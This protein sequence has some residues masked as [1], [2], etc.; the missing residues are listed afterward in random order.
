M[1]AAILPLFALSSWLAL[2]ENRSATELAQS[3][4]RFA[5]SLVAANQD[6]YVEAAQQLLGAIASIPDLPTES[7][8]ACQRE[9]EGLRGRFPAYSDIG[10]LAL[11]G[12]L[13]C[14]AGG[15]A[16]GAGDKGTNAAGRDYFRQAVAQRRFVM[17]E[18]VA[19]G[20]SGTHLIPFAAPVISGG[21]VTAVVFATLS[22]EQTA[23][24]LATLQLPDGARV[25]VSD[26]H[27]RLLMEYPPQPG[28]TVP[29]QLA[30]AELLEAVGAT[31]GGAG[32]RMDSKGSARLYAYSPGMQPGGEGFVALV[33]IDKARIASG[34]VD[35]LR[36]ELLVLALTLMLGISGA[37]WIG[38]RVIVRPAEQIVG[39][40]QR[41]QGGA[42]DARIPMR[43]R[44]ERGEF[45]RIAGAFNLMAESLQMRQQD[46]DAELV[47]SRSAYAVLDL[48]LNSMQD[49]LV[50]VNAAGQF[51]MFNKAA[52]RLFPLQ[53]PPVLLQQWPQLY[54]LYQPDGSTHFLP[55]ELPTA[56]ALRGETGRH[57]QMLVRNAQVP[58]GRLLQCS[59]QPVRGEGGISGGLVVFTDVTALQRLQEEQA[60]QF[61]QLRDTQLKLIEAQRVGKIGNWDTD[62]VTGRLW[63]SE[64]VYRLFGVPSGGFAGTLHDF[65]DRIHPEDRARHAAAREAAITRGRPMNMEYRIIRPDGQIAWMHD[66]AEMRRGGDGRP[67]WYGGVVQDITARKQAEADLVLLRKAVARLNDIV[68]ITEAGPR[69]RIVFVNEAFERLTGFSAQEAI[70]NNAHMLHGPKTD[71]GALERIEAAVAAWQPVR[72][73]LINYTRDGREL[74]LEVDLVPLADENGKH[75]HWIAVERDITARKEAQRALLASER[76]LQDFTRMLQRSADAAREITSRKSLEETLQAV[77][78]QSRH[79]IGAHQAAISLTSGHGWDRLVTATSMSE[80]YAQFGGAAPLPDGS[81]LYVLASES[82]RPLRLTRVEMREH[83]RWREAGGKDRPPLRGL[84][85]VPLVDRNGGT[86]GLLLLSDKDEGDFSERDEYVALEMSQLASIAI[87]NARLLQQVLDFNA[88]LEARIAERTAELAQQERLYRTLAEQ[89]PEVVWNTDAS[90]ARLT[91]LNRAWYE[92]VGGAADDWL[93]RSGL[94]AVHPDDRDEVAAHWRDAMDRLAPISG[95]RRLRARDGSYHTMSYRGSPV[96]D[97]QGQVAFWVGIDTDITEL[98]AIERALRGSNQELEAFSYSVSHD[99]RA[100]LGAIGGF[101]RALQHRLESLDDER[102]HHFLA[103]IQAGVERMEQL[104][105]SLLALAKVVRAPLRYGEVDLGALARETIEGLREAHPGREVR[106]TIHEDL[107][108][109]GDVRLLRIAMEN[110]LGNAW[111]FTSQREGAAIEVGR[112]PDS[113]VFFVRDNGVGFDMAYVDKLFGAFQRLHTEAEFPGTGI[114]LATVRRIVTRHQGRVWGESQVGHGTTFYFVLSE[115][116]PPA[117]L[118]GEAGRPA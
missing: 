108:A 64:E 118:A 74:W 102:A 18:V 84:L 15:D 11:D 70:G 20:K 88:G 53:G 92:L 98:K 31:K 3:Q 2:R 112:L 89:A 91:F 25:M 21:K 6:R 103:R 72:E 7:A 117:W 90:G 57:L 87:E 116:P 16:D 95:V 66:I 62:L 56:R 46:R 29:R 42:L 28:Q 14:H 49:A 51:L 77:A 109:L 93:G 9:F 106:V 30:G 10:M 61:R 59:Y 80:R 73:E 68:L 107:L 94:E 79:V 60:L 85:A 37:W 110:L 75:T 1:V 8:A 50:A 17:G 104:I 24:A 99:L 45:A 96:F 69:Q 63:W 97:D 114:G 65:M 113:R 13:L 111:K 55:D 43:D 19:A 40:V 52:A 36:H 58:T 22:L 86:I 35:A 78:D 4:L 27:G 100:P 48:V 115:L 32:E 23:A 33:S 81:G 54:G 34:M 44:L 82:G 5:A 83:P 12:S 105:E 26:R 47:R 67:V 39:A 71:R 76:E 38:G 101:S 41:L